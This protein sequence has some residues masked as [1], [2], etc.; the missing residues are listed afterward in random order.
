MLVWLILWLKCRPIHMQ[1][2]DWGTWF[3]FEILLAKACNSTFFN[4][5]SHVCF[6]VFWKAFHPFRK[7][8]HKQ[9]HARKWNSACA[10]RCDI[11]Y[12]T[13]YFS[14]KPVWEHHPLTFNSLFSNAHAKCL[15]RS[16]NAKNVCVGS[17]ISTRAYGR[18]DDDATFLAGVCV[19]YVKLAV[20]CQHSETGWY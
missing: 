20:P 13:P 8:T 5:I 17:H 15:W 12:I 1:S 2:P 6:K 10:S 18:M 3:N 19:C 7:C 14:E 9:V 16:C 11:V 4:P